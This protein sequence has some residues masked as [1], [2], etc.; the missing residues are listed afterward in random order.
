MGRLRQVFLGLLLL[1]Q[2]G[3][4]CACALEHVLLCGDSNAARPAAPGGLAG[5]GRCSDDPDCAAPASCPRH[6]QHHATCTAR[7]QSAPAVRQASDVGPVA[8]DWC[9]PARYS[10][11]TDARVCAVDG[12]PPDL[13]VGSARSLP[14]LL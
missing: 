10:R 2:A 6:S 4:A 8:L 14:L 11:L 3:P 1:M 13:P 5:P 7:G 12:E 9:S